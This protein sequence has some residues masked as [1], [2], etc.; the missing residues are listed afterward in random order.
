MKEKLMPVVKAKAKKTAKPAATKAAKKTAQKVTLEDLL[1]IVADIGKAHTET[2]KTLKEIQ[3][4]HK[5]T[6]KA[7]RETQAAHKKTMRET[8]AAIQETQAAHKETEKA[9]RETQAAHKE[10]EKAIRETQRN[11][12]GLNNTMGSLVEHIMTPSLP[13]KF[14]QFG[15]A[16]N[17]IS[18]VK[19][20]VEGCLY[21]EIDGLLENGTQAM[22][23]EVKTTLRRK[24]IDEHLERM[25]R[26]R[27]YADSHG[28][29]REFMGAMAAMVID[30][31]TKTY[32]LSEGLF[33]IEP[34]GEDV[35]IAKPARQKVW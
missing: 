20:A 35:K 23:V 7:I 9:I 15:F 28:D 22:A 12:G 13:H 21:A 10:T 2:E 1:T 33:V 25:K 3:E 16:F 24:D 8:Q 4:A 17:R 18:T 32:A 19:W 26:V 6:E 5:E 27:A 11:I 29:R 14:T 31:D 34:S 30:N